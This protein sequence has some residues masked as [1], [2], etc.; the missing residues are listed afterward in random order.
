MYYLHK[1]V[2]HR[3]H[4]HIF[5]FILLIQDQKFNNVNKMILG[6]ITL[7]NT[8]KQITS[9]DQMCWGFNQTM[10]KI[11]V[12]LNCLSVISLLHANRL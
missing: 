3:Q 12:R 2:F 11:Y 5:I 6:K 7:E 9:L 10:Y 8:L 1:Y 4:W